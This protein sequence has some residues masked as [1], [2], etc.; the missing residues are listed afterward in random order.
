MAGTPILVVDDATLNLKLIRLAL[1]HE[2]FDVRTAERGEDA[3]E[4][5]ST[6][7]P[8]LILADI[9]MPG[10]DGFE[11]TR[12]VK[13]RPETNAIRVVALTACDTDEYRQQALQAGFED[14][15]AKPIDTSALAAKVRK[16]M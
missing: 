15:I 14:Y 3:L 1:T 12:K 8:R 6:Y 13:A 11:L 4:M 9:Q 7:R 16:L 2:G 5:L 10:M